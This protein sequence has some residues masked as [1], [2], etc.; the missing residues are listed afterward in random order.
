MVAVV[1]TANNV[2]DTCINGGTY[3]GDKRNIA[4]HIIR[5]KLDTGII[6]RNGFIN[7]LC[8]I[9]NIFLYATSKH[10]QPRLCRIK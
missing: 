9:R 3:A 5:T 1:P 6:I 7:D 2:F 8:G 10:G 4:R